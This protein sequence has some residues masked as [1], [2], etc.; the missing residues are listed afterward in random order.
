MM[1]GRGIILIDV[2]EP[3]EVS[4]GEIGDATPIPRGALGCTAWSRHAG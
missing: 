4:R 2:R 3:R 1:K